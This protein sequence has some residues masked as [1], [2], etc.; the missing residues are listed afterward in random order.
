MRARTLVLALVFIT[1]VS[2]FAYAESYSQAE[3]N[4]YGVYLYFNTMLEEFNSVLNELLESENGTTRA[5]SFYSL[6]NITAEEVVK[7]GSLGIRPSALELAYRFKA[8]GEGLFMLS[9]SQR[10][11][12]ESLENSN[13]PDAR[14]NLFSMKASLEK[15]YFNL[16]YISGVRFVGENGEAL[17]FDLTKTYETLEKVARLIG[18]YEEM[19]NRLSAPT[20]FT[21][22]SSKENPFLYEN[23]TFYGYTLGLENVRVV[24]NN[25]SYIPEIINGG[26]KLRYSFNEI[27]VYGEY[28]QAGTGSQVVT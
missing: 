3:E 4:D 13:F 18:R 9:S 22:F 23:V 24:I 19:L 17:S 21:I 12:I 26:F 28:A 25:T 1:L 16:E 5:E 14:T 11:F 6:A 8:L 2:E 10:K 27:G 15:I 7:Y 20:E